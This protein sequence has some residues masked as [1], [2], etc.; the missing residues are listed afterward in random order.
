MDGEQ[1]FRSSVD[2]GGKWPPDVPF[3]EYWQILKTAHRLGSNIVGK[4]RV[5]STVNAMKKG[6]A[7]FKKVYVDSDPRERNKNGQTKSGLYRLF[8]DA[9][10][11]LEGFFDMFGFSIFEDPKE[12]VLNDLGKLITI[13]AD[14]FLKNELESL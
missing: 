13:G 3:S 2:E 6:G 5:G 12:P 14:T 10:F 9:G 8:I 11:C 4:S 1:I 7:E